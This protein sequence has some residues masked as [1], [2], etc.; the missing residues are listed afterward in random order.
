M[1]PGLAAGYDPVWSYAGF[2]VV[3]LVVIVATRGQLGY[4]SAA[5]PQPTVDR[6]RFPVQ[7]TS[8]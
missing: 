1:L 5:S 4:R 3:A 8:N 6:N 7:A 2:A